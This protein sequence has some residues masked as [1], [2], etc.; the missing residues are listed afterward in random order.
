MKEDCTWV[1]WGLRGFVV[2]NERGGGE[3]MMEIV[4][5]GAWTAVWV[6]GVRVLAL[7]SFWLL[8]AGTPFP[9]SIT[10]PPPLLLLLLPT[11]IVTY[12]Y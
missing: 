5:R 2:E 8:L 10:P 6:S 9:T 1:F 3:M 12:H 7:E 4:V 11:G